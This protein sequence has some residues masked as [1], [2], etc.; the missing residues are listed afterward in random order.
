M[1][2]EDLLPHLREVAS[3]RQEMERAKTKYESALRLA[4]NEGV[5]FSSLAS[6]AGITEAA[7]RMQFKRRGWDREH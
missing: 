5:S 2:Y 3:A 4:R 6:C 7:I 1:K